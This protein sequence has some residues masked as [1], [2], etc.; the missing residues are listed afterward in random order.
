MDAHNGENSG[1]KNGY[2]IKKSIR[3]LE[4]ASRW[5]L[6]NQVSNYIVVIWLLALK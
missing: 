1:L 6:N 5:A 4:R 3:H 2:V